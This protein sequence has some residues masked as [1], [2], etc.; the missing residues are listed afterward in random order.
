M[1]KTIEIPV[2][3]YIAL[4][5]AEAKIDML[6]VGGVDNWDGYSESL[7]PDLEGVSSYDEI[8]ESIDEEFK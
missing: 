3:E 1:S 5:K 7:F 8:C 6:E 2:S 4:L